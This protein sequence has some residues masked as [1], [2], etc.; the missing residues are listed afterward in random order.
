[1]PNPATLSRSPAYWRGEAVMALREETTMATKKLTG[2]FAEEISEASAELGRWTEE[3]RAV[4]G[5]IGQAVQAR[6]LDTLVTLQGRKAALPLLIQAAKTVL[7][8]L[9]QQRGEA[10]RRQMADEYNARMDALPARQIITD[11]SDPTA[12]T[13]VIRAKL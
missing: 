10:I 5:Q 3:L 9:Y 7:D 12:R 13:V 11:P 1:M 6:D 4:D 8:A 2:F